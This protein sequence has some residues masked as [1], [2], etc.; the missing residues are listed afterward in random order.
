V[1]GTKARA[2]PERLEHPPAEPD[3]EDADRVEEDPE[4]DEQREAADG[5]EAGAARSPS[6][7]PPPA[8]EEDERDADQELED[9]CGEV[10]RP[11]HVTLVV[12]EERGRPVHEHVHQVRRQ[13]GDH[14]EPAARVEET[15]T[16]G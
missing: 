8:E 13:H 10:E 6:E 11:E 3:P 14:R 1:S 5:V 7:R 16:R 9:R 15:E 4:A 12:A 2:E